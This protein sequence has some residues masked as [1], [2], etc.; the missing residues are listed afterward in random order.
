MID[1]SWQVELKELAERQANDN[2]PSEQI[3]LGVQELLASVT[4]GDLLEAFEA[5]DGTGFY[6]E[7]V[8]AAIR[9][10]NLDV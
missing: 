9:A 1:S 10:R 7:T 3:A 5:T 8:L 4:D 2:D 6:A